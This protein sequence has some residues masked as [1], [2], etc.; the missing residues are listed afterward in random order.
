MKTQLETLREV[1]NEWMRLNE[2]GVDFGFYTPEQWEAKEGSENFFQGAELVMIF[3]NQLFN[4]INFGD[5]SAEEELQDL[6]E[7]F[8]YYFECGHAWSIGFYPDCNWKPL[9]PSDTPYNK[10]LEDYRWQKKRKRILE[11]CNGHCEEC[12]SATALEIHHCY[13]RYGREPWQYPDGALLALCPVCHKSRSSIEM[14]FRLFQQTLSISE[15]HLLMDLMKNCKYWYDPKAFH[16]FLR[17]LTSASIA[18]T[19]HIRLDDENEHF[20]DEAMQ[21]IR[22]GEI[23]DKLHSMMNTFGHPTDRENERGN[24]L[25]G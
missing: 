11:R 8:G 7:G 22:F 10:K 5:G 2:M 20:K 15:I 25:K 21:F 6:A 18:K 14:D 1:L 4:L 9:P 12:D 19:A 16:D 17:T 3:E 23:S 13:Y 24:D